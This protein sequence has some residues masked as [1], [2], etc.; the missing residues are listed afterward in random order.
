M[1]A[2]F[3]SSSKLGKGEASTWYEGTK[4]GMF[5]KRGSQRLGHYKENLARALEL[6]HGIRPMQSYTPMKIMIREFVEANPNEAKDSTPK[7][8]P[9]TVKERLTRK[10]PHQEA[11]MTYHGRMM[12]PSHC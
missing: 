5:F 10:A 11:L 4:Q 12:V 9:A 1:G 6:A 8:T 7:T 3:L 2:T